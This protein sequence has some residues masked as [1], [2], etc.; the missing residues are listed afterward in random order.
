M[1]TKLISY[2]HMSGP[3]QV[4]GP[5]QQEKSS[6]EQQTSAFQQHWIIGPKK[7]ITSD[8]KYTQSKH[9]KYT[10]YRETKPNIQR[11]IDCHKHTS[12][13]LQ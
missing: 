9:T 1:I 10:T 13:K 11:M 12:P 2:P 4:D 5:C 3:K 6:S 7:H 8:T